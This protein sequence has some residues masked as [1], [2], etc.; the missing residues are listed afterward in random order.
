MMRKTLPL[1]LLLLLPA[2]VWADICDEA[3][4]AIANAETAEQSADMHSDVIS[5]DVGDLLDV[6]DETQ[7]RLD[8]CMGITDEERDMVQALINAGS[9]TIVDALLEQGAGEVDVGL[10]STDRGAAIVLRA[11]ELCGQAKT[12]ALAASSHYSDAENHYDN[13]DTEMESADSYIADANGQMVNLLCDC[14]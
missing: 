7:D 9:S 5:T 1:A 14:G 6:R 10:G 3:D 11:A 8:F 13:A 2:L 12:R 4:T